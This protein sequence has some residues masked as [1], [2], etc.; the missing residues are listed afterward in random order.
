MRRAVTLWL[1]PLFLAACADAVD[2]SRTTP[3]LVAPAPAALMHLVSSSGIEMVDLGPG[4]AT[5][6]NDRNEVVGFIRESATVDRPQVD[7]PFVYRAGALTFLDALGAPSGFA[8]GINERGDIVGALQYVDHGRA[9]VWRGDVPT[10]MAQ[11]APGSYDAGRGINDAGDVV[12]ESS[13]AP[14]GAV[15]WRSGAMTQLLPFPELVRADAKSINNAGIIVGFDMSSGQI[16]IW[17]ADNT[18]RRLV[19]VHSVDHGGKDINDDGVFV[20]TDGRA[21]GFKATLDGPL[22]YL[23]GLPGQMST[24][25]A[26]N[27]NGEVAGQSASDLGPA[28]AAMWSASGVPTDLGTF[29]GSTYSLAVDLNN[30]GWIVGTANTATGEMR[31]VLWRISS[32]PGCADD[33]IA[34]LMNRVKTLDIADNRKKP[35]LVKLD[36]ACRSLAAGRTQA[37]IGQMGAFRNQ[38]TA[39]ERARE[40]SPAAAAPLRERADAFIARLQ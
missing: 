22:T 18:I 31:A 35:L 16:P 5:G 19:N 24:V 20:G 14:F 17:N 38:V 6:V 15:L 13:A 8:S 2:P 23:P 34:D 40:L 7:R 39:Y 1:F 21:G 12:G 36:A 25:E 37:A 10:L 29:P 27:R 28:I 9:V 32:A 33:I 4:V 26:I 3:H 11:G 30:N